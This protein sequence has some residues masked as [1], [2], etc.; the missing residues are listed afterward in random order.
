MAQRQLPGQQQV[1]AVTGGPIHGVLCPYCSAGIDCRDLQNQQLLDTGSEIEC[2]KCHYLSVVAT[3]QPIVYVT[4]RPT[5]R[6]AN[7]AAAPA[8]VR[9]ATTISQAQAQRL[10]AGPV[11]VPVRRGRR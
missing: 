5:G 8:M 1:R 2:D 9:Q 3:I 10:I 4:V 6:R 11:R 7:T